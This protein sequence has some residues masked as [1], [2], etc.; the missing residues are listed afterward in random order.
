MA[1][2]R[3]PATLPSL[4]VHFYI[5]DRVTKGRFI[6]KDF[7]EIVLFESFMAPI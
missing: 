5:M 3:F 6:H 2:S 4:I 1:A 7:C